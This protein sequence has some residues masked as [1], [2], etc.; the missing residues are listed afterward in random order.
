MEVRKL[1]SKNPTS[2][3]LYPQRV[4]GVTAGIPCTKGI[5]TLP[6]F[7]KAYNGTTSQACLSCSFTEVLISKKTQETRYDILFDRE[8]VY[9]IRHHSLPTS[10]Y[11]IYRETLLK[12][13]LCAGISRLLI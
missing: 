8:Q 6:L 10:F 5:V 3:D 2:S 12:K 11:R 7:H 1:S 9:F 4:F 13:V